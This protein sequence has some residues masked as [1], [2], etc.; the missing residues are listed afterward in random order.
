MPPSLRLLPRTQGSSR[1]RTRSRRWVMLSGVSALLAALALSTGMTAPTHA[2]WNDAEATGVALQAGMIGPPT[3]VQCRFEQHSFQNLVI[4][5]Q[6]P[7][8]GPG[9]IAPVGYRLDFWAPGT[10]PQPT[11]ASIS[12]DQQ[13]RSYRDF[14]HFLDP[15]TPEAGDRYT[16]TYRIRV[17]AVGPG[18]WQS[19]ESWVLEAKVSATRASGRDSS[20]TVLTSPSGAG[21]AV[22]LQEDPTEG[23]LEPELNDEPV[24]VGLMEEESEVDDA[25]P[26]GTT[27]PTEHTLDVVEE[28]ASHVPSPSPLAPRPEG[29][30]PSDTASLQPSREASDASLPEETA[31]EPVEH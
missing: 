12:L 3:N 14:S 18:S 11:P 1:R 15:P 19:A 24:T 20:C 25:A 22:T 8:S 29:A 10:L 13:A 2:S 9:M 4:Q 5:W 26:P 28:E 23:L 16:L 7:E 31:T 27:I 30:T 17:T 6:P 21:E